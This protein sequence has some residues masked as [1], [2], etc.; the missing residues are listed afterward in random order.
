MVVKLGKIA[1]AAKKYDH[2]LIIMRHAKA[3]P[4]GPTGDIDRE[5]TEKGRKQA[6]IAAKGLAE[7]KLIP[8]RIS[9]SS[10][11]RTRQTLDRMLKVFGDKPIV[12]YRQSLY[13]GGMQ[14][15]LDELAQV[16]NKTGIFMIVSHEP[17]VS[18]SS[19]WLASEDSDPALLDMVNLGFSPATV[20]IFGSNKPFKE[21]QLHDATL[22]G[23]I[24][25]KDFS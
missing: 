2:I 12:D 1:K 23:I 25:V 6:K 10:A 7:L 19:Q 20:A 14:S 21:W 24:G 13:V 17:T 5:L 16:K 18:I 8:D 15:V 3:E 22:L 9:C 4:F 11:I